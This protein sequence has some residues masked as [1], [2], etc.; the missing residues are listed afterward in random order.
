MEQEECLGLYEYCPN[1]NRKECKTLVNCMQ[2][3]LIVKARNEVNN[4]KKLKLK[5]M[6]RIGKN[7]L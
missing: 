5:R 6:L 2:R 1:H 7:Q 3:T 4:E